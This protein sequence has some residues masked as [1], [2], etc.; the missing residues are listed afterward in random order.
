MFASKEVLQILVTIFIAITSITSMIILTA[1]SGH[2][3]GFQDL[4][5]ESK[6][7]VYTSIKLLGV[8]LIM[9]IILLLI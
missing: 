4:H 5:P 8:A 3:N 2:A 6:E 1:C 9:G 7:A